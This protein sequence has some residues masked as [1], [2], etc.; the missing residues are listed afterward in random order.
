[1]LLSNPVAA[2]WGQKLI[3]TNDKVFKF[4]MVKPRPS[5]WVENR[6]RLPK[7]T[8]RFP[9]P[10]RYDLTPYCREIIDHLHPSSPTQQIAVMKSSQCGITAGVVIPGMLYIID[11]IPEPMLFTAA[12]KDMAGRTLAERFDP[13]LRESGMQELIR[14][15]VIK[16]QNTRTGDT[17]FSKEYA[18]GTMTAA[19]TSNPDTFRFY[20]AK[21]IFADDFDTA[22][23]EIGDEG[24]ITKLMQG[25]QKSYGDDAKTFYVSTPTVTGHSQIWMQYQKGTMKKWNWV[26]PHCSKQFPVEFSVKLDDGKRAGIVY[27]LDEYG[28]LIPESVKYVTQCCQGELAFKDKYSLNKSGLW[29]ATN[30]KPVKYYESYYLNDLIIPPMFDSWEKVVREWIEA[31]PP[32]RAPIVRKL[33]AFNNQRLGLPFEDLGETPKS[34]VLM[35]NM[36][37]YK[38]GIIPDETS[39]EDGNGKIVLLSACFDLNGELD[40]ARVDWEI[41]A[42]AASGST[43]SVD[44][45]SIGTFKRARDKKTHDIA[46]EADREKMTYTHG[47]PNAVWPEVE[48]IITR[49]NQTEGDDGWPVDIALID[50]GFMEKLVMQFITQMQENGLVVYGVR[51]K[52]DENYRKAQRDSNPVRRSVEHPKKFYNVEVNQ[53]K[54]DISENMKLR[55]GAEGSNQPSGFM[56]YPQANDGKYTYADFFIHYQGERRTEVKKG[57]DVI[58]YRWEKKNSLSPNHFWDVRVYNEAAKLVYLDLAKQQ[59]PSKYKNYTW[60]DF[61]AELVN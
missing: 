13:V 50:T 22:P 48:K 25:R 19:G 1:M 51:G 54:D 41:V 58:G 44:Q 24:D 52:T 34:T 32:G 2:A 21:T 6:I 53:I 49:L 45:G 36:G 16:K 9:G 11:Q 47:M 27:L 35:E 60:E 15:N 8:T 5:E 38:P 4:Q 26:C 31:N 55:R 33:K 7:S 43:Y 29:V 59:N 20:S 42:H 12:D 30:P 17:K 14:P 57:E 18:G 46:K 61:V 10:Y 28:E 39:E 40:D 3:E 23:W 56:N 37:D